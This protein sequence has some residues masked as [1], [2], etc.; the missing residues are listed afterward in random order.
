VTDYLRRYAKHLADEHDVEI[1]IHHRV[2]RLHRARNHFTIDI[3]EG[4]TLTTPIVIAAS[5]ASAASGAFGQ[6]HRPDLP[7][8]DTF[9]GT[10]LHSADYR[11]PSPFTGQRIIVVGAANTA[12]QLATNSPQSPRSPS[13]PANPSGSANRQHRPWSE[14][15]SRSPVF[16]SM[17]SVC[18]VCTPTPATS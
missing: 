13:P 7:G 16:G 11:E 9:T 5:A 8:L 15:C 10:V 6:P 14:R 18:P 1:R 4:T 3:A 12:V 2:A 17:C